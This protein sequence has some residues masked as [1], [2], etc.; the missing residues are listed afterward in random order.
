YTNGR[1]RN[2]SSDR[3]RDT[4]QEQTNRRENR[5]VSSS[6][7]GDNPLNGKTQYSK[8]DTYSAKKVYTRNEMKAVVDNITAFG[9]FGD[10]LAKIAKGKTVDKI[11]ELMNS[12]PIG[13]EAEYAEKL[14]ESGE[15]VGLKK[16]FDL[17]NIC[18]NSLDDELSAVIKLFYIRKCTQKKIA[19]ELGYSVNTVK[20]RIDKAISYLEDSVV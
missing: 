2:G 16:D 18:V 8:S 7:N 9:V 10:E 5:R 11:Y 6:D 3:R 4:A 14:A 19:G 1:G 15:I 17:L 12:A 20:R 13:K